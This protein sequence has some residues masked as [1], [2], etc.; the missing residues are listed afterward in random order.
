MYVGI[1]IAPPLGTAALA[2]GGVE[3]IPAVGAAVTAIALALFAAGYGRR[4]QAAGTKQR[5]TFVA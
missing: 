2:L 4:L 3:A 1:A 5:A